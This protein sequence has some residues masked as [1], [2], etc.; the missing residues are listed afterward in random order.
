MLFRDLGELLK[1]Y[2]IINL[3]GKYF[4]SISEW[5]VNYH[6]SNSP[7]FPRGVAQIKPQFLSS[8]IEKSLEVAITLT[9]PARHP[10]LPGEIA[11]A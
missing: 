10:L 5:S 3:F 7:P 8:L 4:L 2:S 9:E 6:L 1:Y 11:L